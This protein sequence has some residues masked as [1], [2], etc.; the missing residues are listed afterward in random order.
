MKP[1]TIEQWLQQLGGDY[2]NPAE[3][4]DERLCKAL[5]RL[6]L[7]LTRERAAWGVLLA[8]HGLGRTLRDTKK[9]LAGTIIWPEAEP[10]AA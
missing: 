9:A 3:T 4:R 1:K 7:G 8:N 6:H 10:P 2:A 5:E